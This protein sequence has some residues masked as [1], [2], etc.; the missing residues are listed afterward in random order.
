VR[1]TSQNTLEFSYDVFLPLTASRRSQP[2]VG[3]IFFDLFYV[4]AYVVPRG[5]IQTILWSW[6]F[7]LAHQEVHDP[8]ISRSLLFF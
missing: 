5:G 4:A 7:S 6:S 8:L 2:L 1:F 3:D